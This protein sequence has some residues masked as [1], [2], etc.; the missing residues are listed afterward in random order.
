MHRREDAYALLCEHTESES[1]RRHCVAVETA[2]RWYARKLKENEEKWGNTG[3]LHDFDYEKHP[4]DHPRWGMQLLAEQGWDVE[5]IRAIGSHNRRLGIPRTTPLEKHLFACDEITGFI[6]AVTYVRPSKDISDV[7]VS[8]VMKKLRTSAFA[9][10]VD[11]KEIQEG[12]D[13]IGVP[14]EEHTGNVLAAMKGNKELLGLAGVS[15]QP[16]AP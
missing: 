11:R 10:A 13:D 5:I 6:A 4:T 14:L 8:S 2:M 12:A 1:L 16:L 7:E 15:A 9:A 3:L